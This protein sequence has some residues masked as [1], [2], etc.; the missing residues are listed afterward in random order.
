M[1]FAFDPDYMSPFDPQMSK[2]ELMMCEKLFCFAKIS[3]QF[4]INSIFDWD[5]CYRS[6]LGFIVDAGE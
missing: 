1:N 2:V 5:R 6:K 4:I 3:D